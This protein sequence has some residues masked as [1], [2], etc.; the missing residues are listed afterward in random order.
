MRSLQHSR[1]VTRRHAALCCRIISSQFDNI[2]LTAGARLTSVTNWWLKMSKELKN[3]L[4]L[5]QFYIRV[6][7]EAFNMS[8]ILYWNPHVI[9]GHR[10]VCYWLWVRRNLDLVNNLFEDGN[11]W[12]DIPYIEPQITYRK[13]FSIQDFNNSLY[14]APQFSIHIKKFRHWAGNCSNWQTMR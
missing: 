1:E 13:W 6:A 14:R 9:I 2:L 7:M 11:I 5:Y 3:V 4:S 10:H 12:I 8:W